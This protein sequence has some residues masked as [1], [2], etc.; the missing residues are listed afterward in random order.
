MKGC[1][2]LRA[3]SLLTTSFGVDSA[4]GTSLVPNRI[5]EK[6][7]RGFSAFRFLWGAIFFRCRIIGAF[8]FTAPGRGW[9]VRSRRR[10]LRWHKGI[11][12]SRG[13]D[14]GART[15]LSATLSGPHVQP[16]PPVCNGRRRPKLSLPLGLYRPKNS[17]GRSRGP[18]DAEQPVRRPR[19][20]GFS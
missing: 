12:A 13:G 7:Y 9:L 20:A 17:I 1:F 10:K 19:S 16:G 14:R 15:G 6:L 4:F 3:V 2:E 8:W 5:R 18:K 11:C